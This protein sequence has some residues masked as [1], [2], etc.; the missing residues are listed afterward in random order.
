M[1]K[2]L[3]SL[4]LA[5]GVPF[6]AMRAA[7]PPAPSATPAPQPSQAEQDLQALVAR[8]QALLATVEKGGPDFDEENYRTQMQ[9]LA[10]DYDGYLKKNPD[11]APAYAAY[12]VML[13]K[14]TMRRQSAMM[15]LKANEL[16]IQE[17]GK[18][19][20]RTPAL[21]RT[22]ALVKNQLGNYV[23]EEGKPLEAVTYF[24]DAI[25]LMPDE[26]LYHYQ[27]GMLLTEARDDFLKTSQWTR[28]ALDKAMHAAFQRAAELAPDR[29][30]FTYRY[31]ESFYDLE[32][33]D[34]DGAL[35]VWAALEEKAKT[36]FDRQTMRLHAANILI[37]QQKFEYARALLVTVTVE[38]LQKQKQKLVEILN[39][40]PATPAMPAVPAAETA[41]EPAPAP[42]K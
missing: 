17:A 33:P 30:E 3:L 38:Q 11:Y 35:K 6:G 29:I 36:D 39:A 24:L 12:G 10:N 42:A 15:L 23:A 20:A 32:V 1:K 37:K 13:G 18:D 22:W 14:I 27:L 28:P 16:F 19:G 9:D 34:W 31:A 8:Q 2:R 7:E 26:P 21:L 40:E 4:V 25:D 41:P 5:L